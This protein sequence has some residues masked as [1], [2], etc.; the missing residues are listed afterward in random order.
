MFYGFKAES[1]A[2]PVYFPADTDFS[3]LIEGIQE[4]GKCLVDGP[5][6]QQTEIKIRT[7]RKMG[8][9]G[10]RRLNDKRM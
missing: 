6:E 7:G 5:K 1:D 9:I 8:P 4:I 2:L 10:C 3:H